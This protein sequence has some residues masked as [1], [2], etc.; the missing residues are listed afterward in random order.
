MSEMKGK[1]GGKKSPRKIAKAPIKGIFGKRRVAKKAID[2]I[3]KHAED[4]IKEIT[5]LAVDIVD[6][7]KKGGSVMEKEMKLAIDKS[8]TTVK[9]ESLPAI[10][11][12]LKNL[13]RKAAL[14]RIAKESKSDMTSRIRGK[15]KDMLR[16]YIIR[17]MMYIGAFAQQFATHAGRDTIKENDIDLAIKT[18]LK[19]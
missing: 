1:K 9:Q 5:K 16:D 17:E 7:V 3:A 14:S 11:S 15:A 12:D 8:C 10:S 6:Q 4:R 18:M 19:K 2:M 13:V